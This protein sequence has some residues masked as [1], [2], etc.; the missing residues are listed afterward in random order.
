[1]SENNKN[2]R[3]LIKKTILEVLN[4]NVVKEFN[5]TGK[6]IKEDEDWWIELYTEKSTLAIGP[7]DS[8]KI[9]NELVQKMRLDDLLKW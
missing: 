7:A 8:Y 5:V 2:I 3:T 6:L 9:P 1:M 4:E